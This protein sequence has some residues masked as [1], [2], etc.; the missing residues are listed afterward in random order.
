MEH[1]VDNKGIGERIR[2]EREKLA[3]TRE[4]LAEIID[5]S[6]LYIGQLERGE[7]QMSLNTLMKISNCFHVSTD[8]LLKGKDA[9]NINYG[10][11]KS[12]L[13]DRCSEEEMS[14]IEDMI[15]VILPHIKK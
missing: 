2:K 8:Y 9:V 11:Q 5:L 6:P 1:E 14:I 10:E 15:R 3:L 12:S 7:R 4:K 13:I